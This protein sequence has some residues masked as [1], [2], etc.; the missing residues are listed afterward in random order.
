[1]NA[2]PFFATNAIHLWTGDVE[3][4]PAVLKQNNIGANLTGAT[5]RFVMKNHKGLTYQIP[6]NLGATIEIVP[7]T[8]TTVSA[9]E[10]GVTIPFTTEH[11]SA[12]NIFV[13]IFIVT[14]LERQST[15]TNN[16]E[17]ILVTIHAL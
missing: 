11:T 1:M 14:I 12:A 9:A 6:C 3:D 13:G 4:V 8:P 7:G 10:G 16:G 15:F 5:V 2:I 17:P